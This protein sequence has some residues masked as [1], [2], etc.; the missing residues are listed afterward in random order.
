MV[1]RFFQL[2]HREISGLHQAAY[3]LAVFAFLSQILG[4]VRD[5]LLAA[6]FGASSTLDIYYAAFR[7]P[8]FIFISVG[9]MVSVAVLIPFMMDRMKSG[10]EEGKKFLSHVFSFFFLLIVI[11]CAAAFFI[12]PSITAR[13]FPGFEEDQLAQVVALTRIILLSPV[14]LGLSNLLGTLTQ[15]Y[16]R[17]FLYSLSPI[18]YNLGIIAGVIFLYPVFGIAGLAYG[19]IV[20]AFLHLAIQIPFIVE[21]GLFPRLR[22]SLDFAEIR[23]VLAVSLPRT[24]ALGSDSISVM[25]LLSIASLLTAGSISVFSFSYNLQSVPFSIIGVS[26]TLAAFPI[27]TKYYSK[28]E[29][30]KFLEQVITTARH[31]VF[32]TVPIATLF[33]VLRAQIVRTILGSGHFNWDDTRLTAA[34]LAV[35]AV[36][37]VFQNLTLLFVRAYYAAGNTR[38][39][40]FAKFINAASTIALGYIFMI[41]FNTS[42]AFR[43]FLE[44]TLRVRGITGT[45]VL[46]LPLGWSVGELLNT[47][48]L[49]LVFQRDFTGFTRPILKTFAETLASSVVMGAV[50]YYFLGVFDDYFDLNTLAGIFLQGLL[51]GLLG[52]ATGVIVLVLLRNREAADVWQVLHKKFWKSKQTVVGPDPKVSA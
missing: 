35:F 48:A 19:V 17:F 31:I 12:V 43:D 14:L 51:S 1:K 10:S 32:W 23:R 11:V 21:R 37:L 41:I 6:F 3:L 24:F 40:F 25:F 38:T 13:I 50:S 16:Q 28:G 44:G 5:R 26:Y 30:D 36:S 29:R 4:L 8:D 45:V 20:G 9:S 34:A 2:I 46:A 49:W 18:V 47:A 27:L 15:M 52:I 42:P 22:F 33:V 39:P 7:I